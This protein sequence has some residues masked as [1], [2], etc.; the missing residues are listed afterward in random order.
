MECNFVN[1]NKQ[2][3]HFN[4]DLTR[5]TKYKSLFSTDYSLVELELELRRVFVI[6]F[7]GV[8]FA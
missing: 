5:T 8:C 6:C 3:Q 2:Y 7:Q 1:D 4:H